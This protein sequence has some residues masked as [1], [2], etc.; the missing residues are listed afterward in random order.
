MIQKARNSKE[1][2]NDIAVFP[3]EIKG[4]INYGLQR[5]L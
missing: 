1:A 2:G 5:D 4:G 3:E